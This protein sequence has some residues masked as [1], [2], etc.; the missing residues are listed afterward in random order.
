MDKIKTKQYEDEILNVVKNNPQV[1]RITE[2]FLKYSGISRE[3]FY[4]HDLDK[5]D[6]IKNALEHNRTVA[7]NKLVQNWQKKNAPASLQIGAYK[8]LGSE[9]ERRRLSQTFIDSTS[10]I[11]HE[12]AELPDQELDRLISKIKGE[13]T[14]PANMEEPL[15]I[16]G[17]IV[18]DDAL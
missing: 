6:R 9:D 17:E 12:F 16:E 1:L 11:Q 18:D 7:K 13:L 2:I 5:S 8:L 4:N 15:M 3:T 14:E 10:H